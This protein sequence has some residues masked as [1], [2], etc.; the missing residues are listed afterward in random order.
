MKEKN[1]WEAIKKKLESVSNPADSLIQ[2][3]A[4]GID[5]TCNVGLFTR[6]EGSFL[7]KMFMSGDQYKPMKREDGKIFIDRDGEIFQQVVNYLR[8]GKAELPEFYSMKERKAFFQELE[9][10]H[11]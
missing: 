2:L 4:G 3:D 7:A 8:N 6:E 11:I 10:W 1:E 9:F 5:I